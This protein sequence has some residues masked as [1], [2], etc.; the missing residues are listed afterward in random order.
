MVNF[1]LTNKIYL[2]RKGKKAMLKIRWIFAVV[3]SLAMVLTRFYL[4][5]SAREI[6]LGILIPFNKGND[7]ISD[8]RQ[9]AKYYA[10]M[11]PYAR[12]IVNNDPNLL[13]NDTLSFVWNDTEC[14][15]ENALR[16]MAHQWRDDVDAFIGLGCYCDEP[17][18]LASALGLPIISHVSS[19]YLNS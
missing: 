4:K 5:C 14:K 8:N 1:I 19:G 15:T 9:Q 17:A 13:P 7:Y 3:F 12:D 11:I 6:K 16:E 18:R 10:G 2:R